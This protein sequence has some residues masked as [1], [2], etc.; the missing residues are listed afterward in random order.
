MLHLLSSA[1]ALHLSYTQLPVVECG[2]R[3]GEAKSQAYWCERGR[4]A[5]S[6]RAAAPSCTSRS[7]PA[8]D[9]LYSTQDK[10]SAGCSC[11]LLHTLL[12]TRVNRSIREWVTRQSLSETTNRISTSWQVVYLL[13]HRD[14]TSC[15]V[16]RRPLPRRCLRITLQTSTIREM[17]R[18]RQYLQVSAD[19]SKQNFKF[20]LL[21]GN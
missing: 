9:S 10:L 7:P 13:T 8:A 14:R 4:A 11:F 18:K 6:R 20:R 19:L 2:A 12:R 21:V 5:C 15:L 17:L 3:R 1:C 16:D